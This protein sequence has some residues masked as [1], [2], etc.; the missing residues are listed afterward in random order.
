M[1]KNRYIVITSKDKSQPIIGVFFFYVPNLILFPL[2]VNNILN[3]IR[4]V[5]I[6]P[7]EIT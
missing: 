1:E 7:F 5:D 3:G 2:L 4:K 6:L